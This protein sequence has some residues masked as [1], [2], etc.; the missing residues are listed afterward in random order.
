[1]PH[2]VSQIQ[3]RGRESEQTIKLEYLQNLNRL[4]EEWIA[5]YEH[6]LLVVDCDD[7]DFLNR[8]EDF[9]KIT[10]RIDAHFYGL[11]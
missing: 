3:K 4:Y 5:A 8:P 2:L 6:P 11:F 9:A 7:L 10:D 1:M